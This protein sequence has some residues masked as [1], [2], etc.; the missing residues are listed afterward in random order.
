M[1][2]RED[3]SLL[4]FPEFNLIKQ[5]VVV[6]FKPSYLISHADACDIIYIPSACI[7]MH[8]VCMRNFASV[9]DSIVEG[10]L[11][12]KGKVKKS[13]KRVSKSNK[14]AQVSSFLAAREIS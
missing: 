4:I 6:R 9:Q 7:R 12:D 10:L 14:L 2:W 11:V 8:P 1:D 13:K 5:F 3:I